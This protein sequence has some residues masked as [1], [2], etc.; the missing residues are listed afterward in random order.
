MA[1][2][3]ADVFDSTKSKE[4]PQKKLMDRL[5]TRALARQ[6]QFGGQS[7]SPVGFSSAGRRDIDE[8]IR[9]GEAER[10]PDAT[11]KAYDLG[12]SID[13]RK[14]QLS[15]EVEAAI[16]KRENIMQGASDKQGNM[17]REDELSTDKIM[18]EARQGLRD[19][20]FSVF[21]S[22]ADRDQAM[23]EAYQKG[24]LD[25]ELQVAALNGGLRMQDIENLYKLRIAEIDGEMR[26]F[27]KMSEQELRD[28]VAKMDNRAKGWGGILTALE[29]GAKAAPQIATTGVE[30]G[31]W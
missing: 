26:T 28:W 18:E 25:A 10:R 1:S 8:K 6:S 2:Y 14:S 27:E 7:T 17:L 30:K 31:W 20:N 3:G 29:T 13:K 22:Q 11:K 15:D 12:S 24:A 5:E 9:L 4:A 16:R 23:R 19:V 21:K